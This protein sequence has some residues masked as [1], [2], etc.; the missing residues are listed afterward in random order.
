[1][2]PGLPPER[3]ATRVLH[4]NSGAGHDAMHLC[5]ICPAAMAFI[6]CW[7]GISHNEKERAK[8]ADVAAGA[9]VLTEATFRLAS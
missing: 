7:R 5:A 2:N 8:P 3:A 6:P 1:M 9:Q 4:L